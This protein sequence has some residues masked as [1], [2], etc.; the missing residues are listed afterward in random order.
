MPS[1]SVPR[2]FRQE[3]SALGVAS[4]LGERL[5]G[6][7]YLCGGFPETL[8]YLRVPEGMA[9]VSCAR[10]AMLPELFYVSWVLERPGS[11]YT[12]WAYTPLDEA[13]VVDGV[14]LYRRFDLRATTGNPKYRTFWVNEEGLFREQ[15]NG[16]AGPSSP[17]VSESAAAAYDL[18]GIWRPVRGNWAT[19]EGWPVSGEE[20]S[21]ERAKRD[22]VG[23]P[24]KLTTIEKSK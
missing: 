22:T 10:S 6:Y 23:Q 4:L 24:A 3:N 12:S 18:K 15:R 14:R 1:F 19:R 21:S 5:L 16:Q 17:R 9:D 11:P 20:E 13:G 7:R 8:E 2:G